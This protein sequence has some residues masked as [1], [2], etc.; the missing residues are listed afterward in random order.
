MCLFQVKNEPYNHKVD[1]FSMGIILYELLQPFN[2][3]FER[4]ITL[5]NVRNKLFSP[6]F[7]DRHTKEVS[8]AMGVMFDN[9]YPPSFTEQGPGETFITKA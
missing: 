9:L 7:V 4:I 2:T 3:E 1:I 8:Q 6:E 5:N